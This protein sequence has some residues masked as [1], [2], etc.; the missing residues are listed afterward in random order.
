MA[1]EI[2]RDKETGIPLI[3]QT[4]PLQYYGFEV[5]QYS[6]TAS[7]Y[8]EQTL[9]KFAA[10]KES[11]LRAEQSKAERE[12][13]VQQR[14]MVIEKGKREL[15]EVEADANK[16]MKA[17]V[18]DAERIAK[19]ARIEAERKV[20]VAEQA[21]LEAETKA[22]QKVSVA[23]LDL[24][25]AKFIALAADEQAKAI[26][27]LATAEEEKIKKA[28]AITEQERILAEIK[29]DRDVRVAEELAHIGVPR[30]LLVGGGN[31]E[32]MT[33][34]LIQLRLLQTTGI[35][36]LDDPATAEKIKQDD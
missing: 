25:E 11:Y 28:G 34:S 10:K 15:A 9:K 24:E 22:S 4:S 13:E 3:A 26:I 7:N 18:I 21:K 19:V 16:K 6:I 36:S 23:Q 35:I 27:T 8:D 20:V 33:D 2:V 14:L 31:G 29:A 5:L 1:T 17:E 32:D 30:T 12:E